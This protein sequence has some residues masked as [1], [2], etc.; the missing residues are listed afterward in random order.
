MM[1]IWRGTIGKITTLGMETKNTVLSYVDGQ[2]ISGIYA[3]DFFHFAS[4]LML[5]PLGLLFAPL[6]CDLQFIV[7]PSSA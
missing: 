2:R 4:N 3:S 5:K 1:L 6:L 7:W